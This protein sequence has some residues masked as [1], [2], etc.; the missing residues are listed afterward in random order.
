[1]HRHTRAN[2]LLFA[3]IRRSNSGSTNDGSWPPEADIENRRISA[4][5]DDIH[6]VAQLNF[7]R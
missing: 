4:N 5:F 6:R 1:V 7:Y 3:L 2:G